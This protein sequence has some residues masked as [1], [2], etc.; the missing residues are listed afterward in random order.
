M[1]A[2]DLVGTAEIKPPSDDGYTTISQRKK[3][4]DRNSQ[5]I[6]RVTDLS[7]MTDAAALNR[8]ANS[9]GPLP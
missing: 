5:L 8:E 3:A 4:K 9:G 2:S 1:R 6:Q 7:V